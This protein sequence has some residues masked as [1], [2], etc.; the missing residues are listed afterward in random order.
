MKAF[1]KG[2]KDRQVVVGNTVF[3]FDLEGLCEVSSTAT[4]T[5]SADFKALLKMTGVKEVK[6]VV[7]E[8]P[9]VVKKAIPKK[10]SP[11]KAVMKELPKEEPKEEEVKPLL[12]E[13]KEVKPFSRKKKTKKDKEDD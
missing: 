10:P 8:K 12:K 3:S 13:K 6:A 11:P 9:V 2:L 4:P 5:A 7:V 1:C